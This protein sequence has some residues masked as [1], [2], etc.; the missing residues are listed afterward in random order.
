VTNG[1]NQHVRLVQK[2]LMLHCCVNTMAIITNETN[3][4]FVPVFRTIAEQKSIVVEIH[5]K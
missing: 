1:D 4:A 2:M 5:R 3:N